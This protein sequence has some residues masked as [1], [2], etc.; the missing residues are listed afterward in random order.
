MFHVR[1]KKS[2]FLLI[3]FL[4]S[5]FGTGVTSGQCF[6]VIAFGD[7][8]TQGFPYIDYNPNGRQ[9]GGYEVK[10]K[11]LLTGKYGETAVF[12]FGV[13]DET[14][15]DGV[16]RIGRVLNAVDAR[17][18]LILEG[19]NDRNLGISRPTTFKNLSIMI[20]K[21]RNHGVTPILSTL[22]PDTSVFGE[23]KLIASTYNVGIKDIAASRGVPLCDQYRVLV[24][25]W[26]ALTF[27]GLHPNEPGY[28]KMGHEWFQCIMGQEQNLQ[29]AGGAVSSGGGGGGCF[30][31]TAAF[32]SPI[33]AHVNLLKKFRDAYLLPH[34]W[35]QAVVTF[36]YR[37][38]PPIARHIA[39]H[40]SLR[41]LV[42]GLLYPLIGLCYLLFNAAEGFWTA[43]LFMSL[44]LA[45]GIVVIARHYFRKQ[46]HASD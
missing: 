3:V 23:G 8:I 35:G 27:E 41:W 42:R 10:L 1:S 37:T 22:T 14:T 20:E 34:A 46:I 7:S 18:I 44:T 28:N 11:K 39:Q 16:N 15:V 38:S 12:N 2:F 9:V 25:D 4:G 45:L 26:G 31:A 21:S 19:T 24:N 13:G 40:S 5:S 33:E 43:L 17:Y 29:N 30:I 32:G 36:Y 6:Q